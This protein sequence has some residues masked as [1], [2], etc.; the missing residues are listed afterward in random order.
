MPLILA[1]ASSIVER[2]CIDPISTDMRR[3]KERDHRDAE[4][5]AEEAIEYVW[6]GAHLLCRTLK[7]SH[8]YGWRGSCAAGGVTDM[9][10]GS[11]VWLG[12]FSLAPICA[13]IVTTI[14]RNAAINAILALSVSF[15]FRFSA[16]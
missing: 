8:G 9:A 6:V 1:L 11:G 14:R 13:S 12:L 15:A 16:D 10:V 2:P 5:C 4:R 7:M 3:N